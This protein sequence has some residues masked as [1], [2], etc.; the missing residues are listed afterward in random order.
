MQTTLDLASD[1]LLGRANISARQLETTLSGLMVP[2]VD[3]AD[4][5]FQ[6]Q[7][8][9][10]WLLEDGVVRNAGASTAQGVGVRALAGE[11]TGFAYADELAF[12]MLAQASKA[13]AA[14]A[15]EGKTARMNALTRRD[16]GPAVRYRPIDPAAT[17]N[18]EAKV[19]LLHYADKA[20]RDADSRVTRVTVSLAGSSDTMLVAASDGT[21]A[22]DVRPMVRLN[23]SVQ[24]EENGKRESASAGGG[25]RLGYDIYSGPD[26]PV[27]GYAHEAVRRA[28]VRLAAEPAP[29]GALPVVMSP[30]WSG[31]L[32]HEAVGHGL[33]GDF[34]RRG[35]SNYAGKIGQKVAS[36]LCTVVDDGTL[37]G[38]RGSLAVDDEGTPA[39]VNTLIENGVLVG[40]M[41]DKHNAR[42]MGT[43]PTGNAR[44]E[45][46]AYTVMPRMTNTYMRPGDS[47]P[48]D[49]IASVESGIYAAHFGGGSVDITSG[50]FV[51]SCDEAYRIE[52]GKLGAPLKGVTLI[53][54]GPE[55]MG[56]VSMVGN[57][58]ALDTGVGVCGKNGQSVPVGVGQPTLKVDSITVGGTEG[59]A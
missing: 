10:T 21:L 5:Y 12:P 55:V 45:S 39:A 24:V 43:A 4:L 48:G 9:E 11:Q 59:A 41:Q 53:G 15:R 29:A 28:L 50:N 25:G 32:L 44:R 3:Y 34:N 47:D 33:E 17:L 7:K 42:L 40:Y 52:N 6:M 27:A 14:I 51:F 35:A 31:V 30:G 18:A 22:G 36:D 20:A 2:G 16:I 26:D 46:Y 58:W 8:S 54:N 13:A 23:V 37:E 56:R 38:R 1:T 19:A 57:D 49:I